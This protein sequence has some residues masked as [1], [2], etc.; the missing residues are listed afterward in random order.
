MFFEL[1]AKK[2]RPS[3]LRD[4]HDLDKKILVLFL[5]GRH[6][7]VLLEVIERVGVFIRLSLYSRGSIDKRFRLVGY[8]KIMIGTNKLPLQLVMIRRECVFQ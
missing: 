3:D 5:E 7:G 1:D 6:G 4:L 8:I 2:V